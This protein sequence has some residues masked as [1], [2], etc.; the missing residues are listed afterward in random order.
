VSPSNESIVE[1]PLERIERGFYQ[2]REH[3]EPEAMAATLQSIRDKGQLYP[4]IV[5]PIK[6]GNPLFDPAWTEIHYELADGERRFRCCKELGLSHLKALVRDLSDEEMLDY[7]LTT[8]DSLPLNPIEKAMVFS[9]L[10]KE[11]KKSQAEIARSFNLKQQQVSEY[12]RLLELPK[13]IQDL[14]ARAVISVRHARELL[15]ISDSEKM[16]ALAEEVKEKSLSTRDLVKKLKE[17][18]KDPVVRPEKVRTSDILFENSGK[19]SETKQESME[20]SKNDAMDEVRAILTAHIKQENRRNLIEKL[21]FRMIP[22]R[23]YQKLEYWLGFEFG[24]TL[25]P[26]TWL[27][28]LELSLGL[29]LLVILGAYSLPLWV[30]AALLGFCVT[31]VSF[32]YASRTD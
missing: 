21:H 30:T 18:K 9:R 13:E 6:L 28:R 12:I 14:T 8:N 4:V 22:G 17:D 19:N 1:L 20:L 26:E 7:T 29:G 5:R 31:L 3:F 10:A 24:S 23:Y 11:F 16:R 32:L 25:R 15:K 27:I 2:P